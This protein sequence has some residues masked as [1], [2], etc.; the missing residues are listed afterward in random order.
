MIINLIISYIDL[1]KIINLLIDFFN[2][3][4]KGLIKY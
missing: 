4:N 2:H 1:K 3:V